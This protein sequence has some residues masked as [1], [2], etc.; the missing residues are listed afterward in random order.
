M[1]VASSFL[2][3]LGTFAGSPDVGRSQA[4]QLMAKLQSA[5]AEYG[6]TCISPRDGRRGWLG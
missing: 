4:G 3:F 6:T 2:I 1:P 5:S